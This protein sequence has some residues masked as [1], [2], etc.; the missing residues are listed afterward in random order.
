MEALKNIFN[1]Y[2]TG[3]RDMKLGKTLW[4]IVFVKLFIMIF[5]LKFLIFNKTIYSEFQTDED[6]VNFI[7]QNLKKD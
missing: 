5:I 4:L 7:Y 6:R 3:F 1:F 2:Y